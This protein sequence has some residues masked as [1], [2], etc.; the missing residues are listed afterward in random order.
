METDLV[1][2]PGKDIGIHVRRLA[3]ACPI[4]G[5]QQP[6]FRIR[7]QQGSIS[8]PRGMAS[9]TS[10]PPGWQAEHLA[11]VDPNYDVESAEWAWHAYPS[12]TMQESE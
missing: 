2:D 10:V 9:I 1:R 11:R 12:Q 5:K 6:L 4:A 7:A 3:Y 8:S